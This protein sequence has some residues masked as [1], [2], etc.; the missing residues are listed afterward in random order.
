MFMRQGRRNDLGMEGGGAKKIAQFLVSIKC[1]NPLQAV[2]VTLQNT[3]LC[4]SIPVI[5]IIH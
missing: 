3:I 5:S 4:I 2:I 1:Q